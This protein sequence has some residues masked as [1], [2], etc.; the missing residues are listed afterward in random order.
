MDA[1][2][3]ALA[4][5]SI[6][7]A[8]VRSSADIASALADFGWSDL[9]EDEEAFA[10][11]T[12]FEEQGYL[13]V[14]TDA[15]DVVI[16]DG[17][18]LDVPATVIWPRS[19]ESPGARDGDSEPVVDGVVLRSVRDAD[20][21]VLAPVGDSLQA[22]DPSSIDEA[23]LGGMASDTRWVRARVAGTGTTAR[24]SWPDVERRAR[25]AIASELVGLARRII[26]V[27]AEYVAT[28]RQFGRPIGTYQAVRHRLAEAY[29]EMAGAKALVAAAWED[30][31]RAAALVART[32]AG[33]SHDAVA[34]HAIQVFGAIGLSDEHELP[35]LA[36]R[37][38]ALDA[39]LGS[40]PPAPLQAGRDLLAGSSPL[41]VGRF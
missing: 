31:S 18:G 35:A 39:L 25:L 11:T 10:F 26:D 19:A 28:R 9:V 24:G 8:L 23:P 32:V 34:K 33:A 15:L 41:A 1:E 3:R 20:G 36:R 37:G 14:D 38:F 40:D 13:G 5:G 17:L 29:A 30:G 16:T 22:F 2:A 12:L 7:Q 4:R 27:A 21:T 6:R